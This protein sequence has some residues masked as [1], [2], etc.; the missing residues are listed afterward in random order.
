MGAWRLRTWK[1]SGLL[2]GTT[3]GSASVHFEDFFAQVDTCDARI[4]QRFFMGST[5]IFQKLGP[6]S[7][8]LL[9][10]N[11]D[12]AEQRMVDP[13]LVAHFVVFF[14]NLFGDEFAAVLSHN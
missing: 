12:D 4:L 14:A 10:G 7:C 6:V 2:S 5:P 1:V 11:P 3:A 9:N 13:Y 8:L